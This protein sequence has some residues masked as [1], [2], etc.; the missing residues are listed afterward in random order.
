[1]RD[2]EDVQSQDEDRIQSTPSTRRAFGKLKKTMRHG[3]LQSRKTW[4]AADREC[5][6][7]AEE[8][9][10]PATLEENSDPVSKGLFTKFLDEK[11]QL[12]ARNLL[13]AAEPTEPYL[14]LKKQGPSGCGCNKAQTRAW[15][16]SPST[17]AFP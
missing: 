5:A 16:N 12:P 7:G 11:L 15:N 3:K 1:M 8:K 4:T 10:G 9:V 2:T 13:K 17:R 6:R 14:K